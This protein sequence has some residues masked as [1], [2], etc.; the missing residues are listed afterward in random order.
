MLRAA[1]HQLE[2]GNVTAGVNQLRS[3]LNEVGALVRSDRLTG[4]Q[5]ASLRAAVAEV[6]AS[7]ED[8]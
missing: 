6:I 4:A 1:A 8:P 2:R 3:F 7:T 5:A